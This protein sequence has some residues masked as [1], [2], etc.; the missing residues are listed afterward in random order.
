M[1]P[2][3]HSP[4]RLESLRR[5]SQQLLQLHKL[6]LDRERSRYEQIHGP[7]S[8]PGEFLNLVLNHAQFE[9][10]RQLSG[11]IVQIDEITAPRSKAAPD[12]ATST[13]KQ[14]RELLRPSNNGND[15]QRCYGNAL[16]DSPDVVLA[17]AAVVRLLDAESH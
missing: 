14:A 16:Q 13:L 9:W 3:S 1:L 15:F 2:P 12:E 5:I 11:L 7:I 8:S 6:L 10:L 4:E 17:H